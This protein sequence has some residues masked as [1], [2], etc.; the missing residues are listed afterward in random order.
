VRYDGGHC[1]H[2]PDSSGQDLISKWQQQGLLLPLCP[3]VAGGLPVPRPAAEIQEKSANLRVVS[4]QGNDVT[5]QFQNGAQQA[6][7]LCRQHNIHIA[8]LKEGSPSCGSG[9]INDGSFTKTKIQGEGVTTALLRQ[10]GILVFNE[11]QAEEVRKLLEHE[12]TS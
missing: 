7:G 3:E 9:L 12:I 6:L 4:D 8:I 5:H 11:S 1:L 10:H 2:H